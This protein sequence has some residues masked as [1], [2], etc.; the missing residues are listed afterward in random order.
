MTFLGDLTGRDP[1]TYTGT[2]RPWWDMIEWIMSLDINCF[3]NYSL[4]VLQMANNAAMRH[5]C[6]P[7]TKFEMGE[8]L[9]H[10]SKTKGT[11]KAQ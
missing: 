2:L 3:K 11:T 1:D 8:F 10:S 7:P 6:L 9:L 5:I 4:T